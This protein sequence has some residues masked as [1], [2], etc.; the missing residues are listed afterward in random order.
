MNK[1]KLFDA[2]LYREAF[3]QGKLVGITSLILLTLEAVL[4]P[5]GNAISQWNW[6]REM[7]RM[8]EVYRPNPE[9]MS[10][11]AMHPFLMLTFTVATPLLIL[12]LFH[13]LTKR[14]A[15]D[16]Y[17]ALPQRRTCVFVCF[18]GAAMTWMALYVLVPSL[19][20]A[21]LFAA[22]PRY[23]SVNW[24]NVLHVL[25]NVLAGNLFVASS[26]AVA[27]C[28]T[29]TVFSNIMVSGIIIFVPRIFLTVISVTVSSQLPMVPGET[30]LPI[31]DPQYNVVVGIFASVFVG[32]SNPL[33]TMSSGIY[34]MAVGILYGFLAGWLFYRRKSEA[35]GQAA[36]SRKLQL[37]CRLIVS[38]LI[39]LIC[40]SVFFEQM[41]SHE[42][43]D[44]TEVYVIFVIY[45]IAAAVYFLYELLTT[46]KWRN[47]AKAVPGLG[48]LVLLNVLTIF[49]MWGVY[50]VVL[51]TTPEAGD[52]R[53][54]NIMGL[55]MPTYYNGRQYE[56]YFAAKV[57][58]ID[59]DSEEIRELVSGR[60]AEE[61][62]L[63]K[64][65]SR[66]YGRAMENRQC[67]TMKIGAGTGAI[68][69]YI[70]LT[71]E[72]WDIIARTL[73]KKEGYQEGYQ[74][75]PDV[76]VNATLVQVSELGTEESERVYR[77]MQEEAAAM[78]FA[79]WYQIAEN[80]DLYG[81]RSLTTL[82]LVSAIGSGT[83]ASVIPITP[84]LPKTAQAYM[85]ERNRNAEEDRD[86]IVEVL[87]DR[88][89]LE[90]E[91]LSLDLSLYGSGG[92]GREFYFY[93]N[94]WED[95]F[96]ETAQE[97]ISWEELG[98]AIEVNAEKP[99][100]AAGLYGRVD[101]YLSG[102]EE[103]YGEPY[104]DGSEDVEIYSRYNSEH[105]TYYFNLD[106]LDLSRIE[107][108]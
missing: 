17:H 37:A 23:F 34:T 99:I 10:L 65:G 21:G 104:G 13:F 71:D 84:D 63:W 6:A 97:G 50:Q 80:P 56:D 75:L 45:V 51:N 46:R 82:T 22:F 103:L 100:D 95:N 94:E 26:I 93:E 108:E 54:V 105:Y 33:T 44:I 60:L 69:R 74:N 83:Y 11:L 59:L 85:E 96:S 78:D 8:G 98:K 86:K 47:L 68:Y 27:V 1:K 81:N 35:A 101:L 49:G 43:L 61:V 52:I 38:M 9:V 24:N 107:E 53:Y 36:I 25:F 90:Y 102:Y 20:G 48:L 66:V 73:E 55:D 28:L 89:A 29:G 31:L 106:G 2:G 5:V 76:G 15:S 91:D 3:R 18:F 40:C 79:D 64:E 39:C 67:L 19:V 58:G 32:G 7:E 88:S 77:V 30:I 87:T 16:Y 72:D 62:R 92:I 12:Y 70:Y 41:V 57:G 14:N 42:S 4:I